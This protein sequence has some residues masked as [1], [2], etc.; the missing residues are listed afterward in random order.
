MTEEHYRRL[1]RMYHG[2]PINRWYSPKLAVGEGAAT[3]EVPLRDEFHHAAGAVHGSV[4][5]KALDDAAFF[6]AASLVPDVFVLTA[7]F[8]VHFLRPVAGGTLRAGARVVHRTAGS[9]IA[10]ALARDDAGQEL[11]R[12]TGTFVRSK[13]ALDEAMGYRAD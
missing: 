11:A 6:A 10:E 7:S 13:L 9:L 4:V 12:G 8:N 5:F 1:E 2:A 3:L